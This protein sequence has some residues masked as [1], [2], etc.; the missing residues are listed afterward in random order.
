[1]AVCKVGAH[2]QTNTCSHTYAKQVLD[3]VADRVT[4]CIVGFGVLCDGFHHDMGDR[5]M[6]GRR[7]VVHFCHPCLKK[8]GKDSHMTISNIYMN[9]I[10]IYFY[11]DDTIFFIAYLLTA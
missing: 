1:M 6:R 8:A 4:W 10:L 9:I 2:S 11:S 5:G 3:N 7:A